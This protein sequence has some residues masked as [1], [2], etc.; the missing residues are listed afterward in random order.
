MLEGIRWR[1]GNRNNIKICGQPW[2]LDSDNP[3]ITTV[4]PVVENAMVSSVL[5][6][7]RRE[8][9]VDLIKDV[10]NPRDQKSILAIKLDESST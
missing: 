1:I 6:T 8:W 4:S 10:I 7:D 3:Y 2:L 5:C 9:D